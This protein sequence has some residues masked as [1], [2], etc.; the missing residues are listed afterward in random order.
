[1][2][3]LIMSV[4][5][6]NNDP[7]GTDPLEL[8]APIIA[9]GNWQLSPAQLAASA[10]GIRHLLHRA[11]SYSQRPFLIWAVTGAGKTE[12]IYPLI[13]TAPIIPLGNCQLSPAK[14]AASKAGIRH[15]L[16]RDRSYS[17]RPLLSWAVTG[18]GKTEMIFPLIATE[19]Q[20]RGKVLVATPRRDVVLE[21][22]P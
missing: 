5:A 16:H 14:L 20:R 17:Q 12:M 19:L 4:V 3:P 22:L 10:A 21:L 7:L 11:R 8:T 9:L 13:P 18:A 1:C 6:P 15:L 2:A